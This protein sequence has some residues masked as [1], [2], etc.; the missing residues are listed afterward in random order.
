[1]KCCL[2]TINKMTLKSGPV[3]ADGP[4]TLALSQAEAQLG[5]GGG[6]A[7]WEGKVQ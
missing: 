4:Q 5:A 7:G 2:D 1:M 3:L 6:R